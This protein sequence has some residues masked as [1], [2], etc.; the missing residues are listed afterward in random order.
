MPYESYSFNVLG[1]TCQPPQHHSAPKIRSV[2]CHCRIPYILFIVESTY[3][4]QTLQTLRVTEREIASSIMQENTHRQRADSSLVGQ[5]TKVNQLQP[6]ALDP[7]TLR[8]RTQNPLHRTVADSI[9]VTPPPLRIPKNRT[10]G[11][12]LFDALQFIHSYHTFSPL[13]PF[14]SR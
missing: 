11:S 3:F 5:S 9:T 1:L 4:I 10:S 12:I 6:L 13:A 14:S 7:F 8:V 2:G